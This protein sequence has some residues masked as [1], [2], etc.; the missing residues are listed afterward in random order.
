MYADS[1][2]GG[3]DKGQ[4]EGKKTL[5]SKIGGNKVKPTESMSKLE[6]VAEQASQEQEG[7][8]SQ[9]KEKSGSSIKRIVNKTKDKILPKKS[10]DS[11]KKETADKKKTTPKK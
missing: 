3:A 6:T 7:S 2:N 4:E 10:V 11:S 5:R 1:P 9:D 8:Q